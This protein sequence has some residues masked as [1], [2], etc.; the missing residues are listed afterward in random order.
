MSR[1]MRQATFGLAALFVLCSAA[2]ATTPQGELV[3]AYERI[4]LDNGL[5]VLLLEHHE[6]P[7]VDFEFRLRGGAVGDPVGKEGLADVT[8]SMMRKGTSKYSSEQLSEELDFLGGTLRMGAGLEAGSISAQFL[9]KDVSAGLALLQEILLHPTFPKDEVRKT[10]DRR[11]D[12]IREAKENPRQVLGNYYSGFL[13]GE[14]PFGRPVG[15]TETS[16]PNIKRKDI[17]QFYRAMVQPNRTLLAVVGDFDMAEM[18]QLIETTFGDWSRGTGVTPSLSIPANSSGTWVLLVDKPDATQTYFRFGNVGVAKGN[19]D[20]AVLSLVNTVFGGRFTSWLMYEMRTKNGLTY[21]ARSRF[22]ER[23]VPG[24]FY[25]SSFTR[26]ADTEK[27]I[28]MALDILARLHEKGLTESELESARNY[29]RGQFPPDF[30]TSSDLADAIIELEFF[31][32]DRDYINGRTQRVDAVTVEDVRRAIAKHYPQENLS[33]VIVGQAKEIDKIA[34]KYG[35]VTRRK[36][37]DVGF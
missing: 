23:S 32:L 35:D 37:S 28:D 11:V 31:G 26:T 7:L 14:H 17:K 27:A 4:E 8:L 25:I 6:L 5:I 36:I 9:T 24:A 22:V 13:F 20:T 18:R 15:G 30:E 10:L 3:P 34:A 19:E 16:L 21:S 1:A 33:F 12:G 29:I 2:S